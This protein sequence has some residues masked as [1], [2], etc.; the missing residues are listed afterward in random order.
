MGAL[1]FLSESAEPEGCFRPA[2]KWTTNSRALG[3]ETPRLLATPL[4]SSG[5]YNL[6]RTRIVLAKSLLKRGPHTSLLP[7]VERGGDRTNISFL[8]GVAAALGSWQ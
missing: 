2:E 6:S 7:P 8:H 3:L 5:G 1:G 4:R